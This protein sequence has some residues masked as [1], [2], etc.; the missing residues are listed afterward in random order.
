[1]DLPEFDEDMDY[2][3]VS[4]HLPL[5]LG[6]TLKELGFEDVD[7][8]KNMDNDSS[9]LQNFARLLNKLAFHWA[10]SLRLFV[11]SMI[12]DR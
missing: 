4:H 5:Q 3:L 10:I 11:P 7:D 12:A 6:S 1:M 2:F 8:Y 9:Q